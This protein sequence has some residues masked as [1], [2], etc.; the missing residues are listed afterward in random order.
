[1]GRVKWTIKATVIGG[2]RARS[3]VE[4]STEFYPIVV[5]TPDHLFAT[6]LSILYHDLHPSLGLLSVSLTSTNISVGGIMNIDIHSPQPPVDILVYMIRVTLETT[7]ELQTRRRGKQKVPVQRH[8]LFEQGWVPPRPGSASKH[9]EGDPKQGYI[10]SPGSDHAWSVQSTVRLPD[11]NAIRATTMPGSKAAIRF[12]HTLLVEIV[13]SRDPAVDAWLGTG[14]ES[15][16]PEA[17]GEGERKIKVFALRQP[18][19][20]PS[21]C[22]AY[23]AVTLPRYTRNAAQPTTNTLG[24][25]AEQT[26]CVC[27]ISMTELTAQEQDLLPPGWVPHPAQSESHGPEELLRNRGKVGELPPDWHPVEKPG[28]SPDPDASDELIESNSYAGQHTRRVQGA[29]ASISTPSPL[30]S[31]ALAPTRR[32]A[33]SLR[34][35]NNS[36]MTSGSHSLHPRAYSQSTLSASPSLTTRQNTSRSHDAPQTSSKHTSSVSSASSEQESGQSPLP[37]LIPRPCAI[38]TES[39]ASTS[40]TPASPRMG[41]SSTST[42]SSASALIPASLPCAGLSQPHVDAPRDPPSY[43]SLLQEEQPTVVAPF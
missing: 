11:D 4:D 13:H 10:R 3:N 40:A 24:A 33:T 20:I 26:H 8:R 9:G 18:A 19:I 22:V 14:Q 37:N 23:N 38:S 31:P 42:A 43:D 36:P 15:P 17:N 41:S 27:G 30:S 6:P 28:S 1:M 32:V 21:C 16:M 34:N 12:T 25:H 5:P 35:P 29:A 39:G 2:G 7:T